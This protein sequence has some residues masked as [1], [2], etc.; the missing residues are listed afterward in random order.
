MYI[1]DASCFFE[2]GFILFHNVDSLLLNEK[3]LRLQGFSRLRLHGVQIWWCQ[4]HLAIPRASA[5]HRAK[6]PGI[7]KGNTLGMPEFL[8]KKTRGVE[9]E[10]FAKHIL[11]LSKMLHILAFRPNAHPSHMSALPFQKC[12]IA[13]GLE[14]KSHA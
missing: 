3:S 1:P 9:N 6:S 12:S 11:L 5:P 7:S 14:A 8:G 4:C 10:D 13:S 2:S